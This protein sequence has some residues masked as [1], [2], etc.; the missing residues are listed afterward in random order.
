VCDL[1]LLTGQKALVTGANSGIGLAT[2]VALG[3][4]GADVVVNY[5]VGA[6]EAEN[7]VKEIES[8]GVRA[9]AHEADVSDEDQVRDMYA[10]ARE[11]FGRIDVLFNNAGIDG[12]LAPLAEYDPE[13]FDA[14]VAV[15]LRGVFLGIRY[16]VPEMR[17]TGGGSIISTSSMAANVVFPSMGA[18]TATKAGVLGLTRTAAVENAPYGIRVNAVLPGV[19][20]TGMTRQL[21]EALIQGTKAA[22]PLGYIAHAREVASVA[23]FLATDEASYV[24]GQGITV[25][26][27]YTLN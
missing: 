13:D 15:N 3:R 26:G 10:R 19:I 16:A 1:G 5:V 27:G 2:A 24:T 14:V 21:P 23:L 9:Y 7:V 18:Y 8:F 25:D 22:T 11:A 4:A 17:K 12:S 6:H 20:D